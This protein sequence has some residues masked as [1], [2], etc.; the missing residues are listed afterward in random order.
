M[1]C[2]LDKE[3]LIIIGAGIE[4]E[5]AYHLAKK[6]GLIIVAT[7]INPS[8]HCFHL[9]DYCLVVST[10]DHINTVRELSKFFENNKLYPSGVV[11]VANDVPYT[12]ACVAEHFNLKG[13]SKQSTLLV[14]NKLEMKKRFHQSNVMTPK[15]WE[16][17]SFAHFKLLIRNNNKYI[18]KPVDGRGA[19]GVLYFDISCDLHFIYKE[20]LR[21]SESQQVILEEYVSGLQLSTESFILNQKCYTAVYCE[22]NYDC[23]EIFKPNII[24]NGGTIPAIISDELKTK[25][26]RLILNGSKSLNVHHGIVK[27][28]IVIDQYGNPQIIELALR[29]S[30]GWFATD[31]IPAAT[32]IDLVDVVI[33]DALNKP[34]LSDRLLPKYNFSTTSR[35][36][37]PESGTVKSIMNVDLLEV[38]SVI[39][40]DFFRTVG[41]FQPL[42]K[43]HPDRFGYIIV[44]SNT[45]AESINLADHLIKNISIEVINE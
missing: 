37:F 39:K 8:A 43:S 18:V 26:D 22:R 3:V 5:K 45:R 40:Y 25:I 24:E 35:Y 12:V 14:T 29:L 11:T 10:R 27:G 23:L 17:E 7:D 19:R 20:S 4:Q 38:D 2:I 28:D 36:I 42:V 16:I 21:W 9:S 33:D 1:E 44:K 30:G 15:F 31:Q 13:H 41:D 6:K 32:G 34:I